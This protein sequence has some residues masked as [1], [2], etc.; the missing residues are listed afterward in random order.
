MFYM[1]YIYISVNFVSLTSEKMCRWTEIVEEIY[2]PNANSEYWMPNWEANGAILKVFGMTGWRSRATAAHSLTEMKGILF[3]P[4]SNF[5]HLQPAL[6]RSPNKMNPRNSIRAF[7]FGCTACK[8]K[9]DVHITTGSCCRRNACF[10][11]LTAVVSSTAF[12]L[13]KSSDGK[14]ASFVV[15]LS[16]ISRISIWSVMMT[17]NLFCC[18]RWGHV[19]YL[20]KQSNRAVKLF[21]QLLTAQQFG[22][23]PFKVGWKSSRWRCRMITLQH[24]VGSLNFR[25]TIT[26]LQNILG[27]WWN[28]YSS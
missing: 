17:R 7:F 16:V 18:D 15:K 25:W 11:E 6:L 20:K 27:K 26:T 22:F 13:K 5:S 14:Q 23:A 28:W 3:S 19:I 10:G 2:L 21:R 1:K 9:F 8:Q 4:L 24:S 12:P